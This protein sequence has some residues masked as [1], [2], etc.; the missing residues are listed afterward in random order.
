MVCLT[1]IEYN[2]INCVEFEESAQEILTEEHKFFIPLR[3]HVDS[4]SF[5]FSFN[6]KFECVRNST[7]FSFFHRTKQ[8][9]N[10]REFLV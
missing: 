10:I 9:R 3:I 5:F 6:P 1:V 4:A 7:E 2:K 8:A